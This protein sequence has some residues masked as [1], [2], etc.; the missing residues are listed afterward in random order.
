M[1]TMLPPLAAMLAA[2]R[3]ERWFTTKTTLPQASPPATWRRPIR[4]TFYLPMV[5]KAAIPQSGWVWLR[6]SPVVSQ[7]TDFGSL[8]GLELHLGTVSH[9]KEFIEFNT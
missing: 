6:G 9:L 5:L 3:V 2:G 4:P 8:F 7:L 1:A